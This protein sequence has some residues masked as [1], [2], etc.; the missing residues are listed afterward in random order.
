M[1]EIIIGIGLLLFAA[2]R[3]TQTARL[4]SREESLP[5][6][7]S[8]YA[9]RQADIDKLRGGLKSSQTFWI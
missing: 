2:N 3:Y 9:S 1:T 5:P 4:V 6:R 8:E 7:P